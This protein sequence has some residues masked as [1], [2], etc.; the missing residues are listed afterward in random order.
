MDLY[1][2]LE[3]FGGKIHFGERS[4]TSS[5]S[6]C[7]S[8]IA[9]QN[10]KPQLAIA[11]TTYKFCSFQNKSRD[12]KVDIFFEFFPS[13]DRQWCRHQ[14][15]WWEGWWGAIGDGGGRCKIQW[16]VIGHSGKQWKGPC[17]FTMFE[18]TKQNLLNLK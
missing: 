16:W 9:E 2:S 14:E 6:F 18:P 3:S 8:P 10:K 1:L 5:I 4:A 7:T 17:H 15:G 12:A 13:N 11:Q